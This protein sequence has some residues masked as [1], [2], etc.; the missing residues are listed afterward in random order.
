MKLSKDDRVEIKLGLG[1]GGW[2]GAT[3]REVSATEVTLA[4]DGGYRGGGPDGS[5]RV[6][7]EFADR[8][9]RR[10]VSRLDAPPIAMLVLSTQLPEAD[11][12]AVT[13]MLEELARLR[14]E[15]ILLRASLE[16]FA[17][18]PRNGDVWEFKFSASDCFDAWRLLND[19]RGCGS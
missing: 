11:V 16:S 9:I 17:V 15:N 5:Y 7:L 8:V 3:V 10:P 19:C 12:E 2:L 14:E 13:K 4:L 18:H 6:P 1:N